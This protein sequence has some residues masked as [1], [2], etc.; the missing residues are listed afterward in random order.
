LAVLEA[1]LTIGVG[2]VGDGER[3]GRSVDEAMVGYGPAGGT[4]ELV[5]NK[6]RRKVEEERRERRGAEP[7]RGR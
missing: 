2:G 3:W 4:G 7:R 6:T 1:G 5:V